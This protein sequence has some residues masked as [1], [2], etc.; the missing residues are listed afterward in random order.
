MADVL[1]IIAVVLGGYGFMWYRMGKLTSE[2]HQH[3]RILYLI[4]RQLNLNPGMIK[5]KEGKDGEDN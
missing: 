1:A 2:V 3:N 4:L 5:R